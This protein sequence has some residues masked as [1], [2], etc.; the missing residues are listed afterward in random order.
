MKFQIWTRIAKNKQ[1]GE[2]TIAKMRKCLTKFSRN[3]EIFNAGRL[4]D[5]K[6]AKV[7]KSCRS[8]QG[9]SKEYLLFSIYFQKLASIHPIT[10]LSKFAKN[11]PKTS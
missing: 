4:L 8:R 6:G 11:W 5:S 3:L 2:N 9:L 7:C 1:T 10:G